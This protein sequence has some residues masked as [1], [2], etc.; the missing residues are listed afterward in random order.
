MIKAKQCGEI[1]T[2]SDGKDYLVIALQTHSPIPVKS[3]T[4]DMRRYKV[5][6][7]PDGPVIDNFPGYL[8]KQRWRKTK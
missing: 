2:G 4:L 1:W 5:Q 8:L 6:C 3:M 7:G